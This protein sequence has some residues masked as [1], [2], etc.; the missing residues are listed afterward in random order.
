MTSV[1]A[2]EAEVP[3][4]EASVLVAGLAAPAETAVRELPGDGPVLV[5]MG[6]FGAIGPGLG[7]VA[8]LER[9]GVDVVVD[10]EGA[11]D[12][13]VLAPGEEAVAILHIAIDADIVTTASVEGFE[14]VALVGDETMASLQ[15]YA[16]REAELERQ[17]TAGAITP[18]EQLKRSAAVL[19][20]TYSAAA[21]FLERPAPDAVG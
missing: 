8:E 16:E 10:H 11:G 9:R 18:E 20:P 6:T 2:S 14:L 4:E 3:I 15:E 7:L 19:P 1:R 17:A 13:R 5:R 21:V 12:H